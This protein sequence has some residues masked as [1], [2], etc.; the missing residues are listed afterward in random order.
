MRADTLTPLIQISMALVVL[1]D[2]PSGPDEPV[3]VGP[4]CLYKKHLIWHACSI[5]CDVFHHTIKA[6]TS[7]PGSVNVV[8]WNFPAFIAVN[9]TNFYLVV[10]TLL[11]S[12]KMYYPKV[13][14]MIR[15]QPIFAFRMAPAWPRGVPTH[16]PNVVKC[17]LS[18]CSVWR[19][20]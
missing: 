8:L 15:K 2:R 13:C 17:E 6:L 7:Y 5:L 3:G 18:C 19:V 10:N 9:Q 20:S 14:V 12:Q 1:S 4:W 11:Y 16:T